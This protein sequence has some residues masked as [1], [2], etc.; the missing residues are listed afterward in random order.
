M[1]KKHWGNNQAERIMTCCQRGGE[2]PPEYLMKH[3]Q[4]SVSSEHAD[5]GHIYSGSMDPCDKTFPTMSDTL[6]LWENV[7]SHGSIHVSIFDDQIFHI[8]EVRNWPHHKSHNIKCNYHFPADFSKKLHL[9]TT[10]VTAERRWEIHGIPIVL[11]CDLFVFENLWSMLCL[12]IPL[13]KSLITGNKKLI[14]ALFLLFLHETLLA[15][16]S[17]TVLQKNAS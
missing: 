14:T 5:L 15:Y 13:R 16:K 1:L 11:W 12:S 3:H 8:S 9:D 4:S 6:T 17:S 7:L 10:L 2:R